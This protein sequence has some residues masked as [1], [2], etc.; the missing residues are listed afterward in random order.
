MTARDTAMARTPLVHEKC[1]GHSV[2]VPSTH[3]LT[4]RPVVVV[5]GAAAVWCNE[6]R[7]HVRCVTIVDH[8]GDAVGCYRDD[9]AGAVVGVRSSTLMPELRVFDIPLSIERFHAA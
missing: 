4:T 8:L 1:V 9:L 6:K 5:V 2:L 3:D 7:P